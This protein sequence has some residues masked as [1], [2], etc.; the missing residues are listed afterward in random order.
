MYTSTV[1]ITPIDYINEQV[2]YLLLCHPFPAHEQST[3]G[4]AIVF[5]IQKKVSGYLYIE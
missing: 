2:A 1:H 4:M 3:V 5:Q